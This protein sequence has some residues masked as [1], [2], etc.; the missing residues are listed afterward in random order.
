MGW[1]L[2]CKVVL[3]RQDRGLGLSCF[4]NLWC[5]IDSSGKVCE[6]M[7]NHRHPSRPLG[8]ASWVGPRN[9]YFSGPLTGS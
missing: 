7:Q 4:S 6:K 3:E 8:I 9:L 5:D 2:V 1:C